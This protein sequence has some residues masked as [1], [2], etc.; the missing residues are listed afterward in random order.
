MYISLTTR[1]LTVA[2]LLT[3]TALTGA[4]HADESVAE[5]NVADSLLPLETRTMDVPTDSGLLR[6]VADD[7]NVDDSEAEETSDITDLIGSGFFEGLVD[8]NGDVDL[9]LGITVFDAMG[10]TSIG[11]GSDF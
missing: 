7:I 2:S 3:A 1:I 11:F 9:P 6:S 10:T 8:E 4:V 5:T